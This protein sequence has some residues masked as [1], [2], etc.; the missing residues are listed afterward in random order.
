MVADATSITMI[1]LWLKLL[2]KTAPNN[3]LAF[4]DSDGKEVKHLERKID[5]AAK[6]LGYR[7]PTATAFRKQVEIR[8]KRLSGPM[9]ESESRSLSHSLTTAQQ[10]YQAS[11]MSDVHGV[12]TIAQDI[13]A[14]ARASSPVKKEHVSERE[15]REEREREQS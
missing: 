12:Y 9:R 3:P 11:T 6:V 1:L 2:G 5:T 7:L 14:G 15:A 10:Y 4:P 8:N 13:I